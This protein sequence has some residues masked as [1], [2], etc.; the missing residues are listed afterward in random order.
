[1]SLF[2]YIF[3]L[4]MIFVLIQ[5]LGVDATI[6]HFLYNSV[7]LDKASQHFVLLIVGAI[8][9]TSFY[10]VFHTHTRIH[11]C[12]NYIYIHIFIWHTTF[13][14][15]LTFASQSLP[16]KQEAVYNIYITRP[17]VSYYLP[18]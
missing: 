8:L 4:I 11:M 16:T 17:V 18:G 15:I 7:G 3:R 12:F 13:R 5:F 10:Q 2:L 6:H 9:H 14:F 1:M